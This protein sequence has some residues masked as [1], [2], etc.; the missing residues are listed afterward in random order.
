MEKFY[1]EVFSQI[2]NFVFTALFPVLGHKPSL[3][4]MTEPGDKIPPKNGPD[5]A[6]NTHHVA[7]N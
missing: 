6:A 7:P 4:I 1:R 5:T 2:Y 3:K